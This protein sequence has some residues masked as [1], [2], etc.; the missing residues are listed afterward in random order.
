M[1]RTAAVACTLL[2]LLCIAAWARSYLPECFFLRIHRGDLILIFVGEQFATTIDP[3]DYP[4]LG[5][6]TR[7][8]F[9]PTYSPSSVETILWRAKTYA[10]GRPKGYGALWDFAGFQII[11]YDRIDG[12]V[13]LVIPLWSIVLMLAG[14]SGWTWVRCYRQR[15]RR[16]PGHCTQ[17]GYD[18]RGSPERCPECGT[19]PR[20]V[21]T[22]RRDFAAGV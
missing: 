7:N 8:G 6:S 2:L 21:R 9:N 18:L 3:A 20:A 14:G 13:V 16:R 10:A 17:C 22:G 11:A 12:Y 15:Q 4:I 1:N 19:A 5:G